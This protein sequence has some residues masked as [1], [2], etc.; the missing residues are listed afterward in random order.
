[1]K[2]LGPDGFTLKFFHK[3]WDLIK[4]GVWKVVEESRALRW[5]YP[6]LNATFIA[7]IPKVEE[8]NTPD[9]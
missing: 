2:A 6:G 5:M 3:F 4:T 8:S 9:K 7:L 1:V